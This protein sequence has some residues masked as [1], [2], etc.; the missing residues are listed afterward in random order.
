M[1]PLMIGTSLVAGALLGWYGY[2]ASLRIAA[3][4]RNMN[5]REGISWDSNLQ[6]E[7]EDDLQ[8]VWAR[9]DAAYVRSIGSR[10]IPASAIA[11]N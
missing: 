2:K 5:E 9:E 3:W 1:I 4:G 8:T 11:S 7:V 10:Q 6:A